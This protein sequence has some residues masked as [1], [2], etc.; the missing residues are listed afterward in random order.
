M[1]LILDPLA[2]GEEVD[3][4]L[5]VADGL[6]PGAS[7]VRGN[8]WATLAVGDGVRPVP[9]E[10]FAGMP[11][12]RDIIPVSAPYR[13][14]SRE[15]FGED[16]SVD[17][18]FEADHE[19]MVF[20][21]GG[22]APIGLI[23]SSRWA[24]AAGGRLEVL[25]PVLAEAGCRAFHA[26]PLAND[27]LRL[28]ASA[29]TQVRDLLHE[30]GLALSIEVTHAGEIAGAEDVA[31][32]IL[33]GSATMQDFSL[34]R[35][36][37]RTSKPVL[38][39][40]GPGSTVEE[41]LLAAEYVLSY[42]NGRLILCESGIRTF[43]ALRRPRFE[44]NAVPLL[45][46]STHL[47]L[48]ADP[49]QAA[50]HSGVVPAVAR[51][52]IAAGADGLIIEVGTEAVYDPDGTAIDIQTLRRLTAELQPISRAIGRSRANGSESVAPPRSANEIL[53]TTDRTL[54]QFIERI[55]GVAPDLDVLS[56]WRHSPPAPEWLTPPLSS[57]GEILGRC[58]GYRMGSVR[59]SRN[60]AYVDLSRIDPTLAA[61]LES[62]QLNLGQLFVDPKIEKLNFE[63]GTQDDAGR[64]DEVF[65]AAFPDEE[66][67][68]DEY[69]WRRYQASIRGVVSFVVIEALP[70]A[71]WHKLIEAEPTMAMPARDR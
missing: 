53:Q 39:K 29:A 35:E 51:A 19:A 15:V 52:A 59:L 34:L 42:G 61:L 37:G 69:V 44:I 67:P 30:R 16:L 5:T 50:P 10:R 33:V 2:S 1:V 23:A 20:E 9:L 14:A 62:E 45:K 27:G 3:R 56:Q 12:F 24:M 26:G 47:P 8:G 22:R 63:F 40:R 70:T 38:L 55:V 64:I 41:F 71:T 4:L 18:R 48:V 49:S 32:L 58:T 66:P 31:D 28:G 6:Q 21:L 43:D 54:A 60:L 57:D 13:L 46:R 65:R 68:F 11:G 25:A 17:I 7:V 36:L